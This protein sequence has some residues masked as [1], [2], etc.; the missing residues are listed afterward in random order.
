MLVAEHHAGG[1]PKRR[2]RDGSPTIG[3]RRWL[4]VIGVGLLVV[5]LDQVG[6]ATALLALRD[7]IPV[8]PGIALGLS[9]NTG[10]AFSTGTTLTPLITAIA[11][12][13]LAWIGW[14]TPRVAAARW[15]LVLGLVGGGAA[16]NLIDRLFRPPGVGRGAVVDFID[17]SWF[18]SFNLAD[19][20]L[21]GG[22]LLGIVLAGRG[23]PTLN[24]RRASGGLDG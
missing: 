8:A 10:A 23:I 14:A 17:V 13:V 5:V 20:A 24:P 15:A 3:R 16:G 21:T 18:A 19:V 4:L 12:G 2:L 1:S 11:V 6:K 7:P 9:F 22:A